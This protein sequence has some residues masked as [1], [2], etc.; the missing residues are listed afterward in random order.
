MPKVLV[1]IKQKRSTVS[2]YVVTS[3]IK[4]MIRDTKLPAEM[5]DN[6]IMVEAQ[7]GV[8]NPKNIS[9][10]CQSPNGRLPYTNMVFVSFTEDYESEEMTSNRAMKVMN[11]YLFHDKKYGIIMHP[12]YTDTILRM[13][14]T[15]RFKDLSA[16]TEWQGRMR[17]LDRAAAIA[18]THE[19]TYDYSIPYSFNSFILEAFDMIHS[20]DRTTI[21]DYATKNYGKG[22]TTRKNMTGSHIEIIAKEVQVEVKG[23]AEATDFYKTADF[24]NGIHQL[25]F[26]HRINFDQILGVTLEFPAVINNQII[27][28]KWIKAWIPNCP[29][30][31]PIGYTDKAYIPMLDHRPLD[32]FYRGDGG[33]RLIEWDDWFPKFVSQDTQTILIFPVMVDMNDRHAMFT[34]DDLDETVLPKPVKDYLAANVKWNGRYDESIIAIEHYRVGEEEVINQVKMS[35]NGEVRSYDPMDPTDRNYVRISVYKDLS[36]FHAKPLIELLD[37]PDI[38]VPLL[39]L[40][41]ANTVAV[42]GATSPP[43]LPSNYDEAKRVK[44]PSMLHVL[45][46]GGITIFSFSLWLLKH[47]WVNREYKATPNRFHKTVMQEAIKAKRM[48]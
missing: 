48:E 23:R 2:R 5:A 3:V 1:P 30:N 36:K 6:I 8:R 11:R 25:S 40:Y 16:L 47:P 26:S 32:R 24:D 44:Y 14:I 35:P 41:D 38:A 46:G 17:L 15:L 43:E 13:D 22:V 37:N 29:V 12:E 39:K 20:G 45:D 28:E 7:G 33:M 4:D 27:D 9:D 10:A 42:E 21:K 34:L 18:L 19:I 31:Q